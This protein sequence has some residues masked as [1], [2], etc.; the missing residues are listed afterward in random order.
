MQAVA[1]GLCVVLGCLHFLDRGRP[2][3]ARSFYV[4]NLR[5]SPGTRAVIALIE[6]VVGFVLL[7]TA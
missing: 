1:G 2:Q 3:Q 6:V 4:G 5:T 7:F